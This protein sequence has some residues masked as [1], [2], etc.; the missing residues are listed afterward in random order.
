MKIFLS[1]QSRDK[2]LV[3]EFSQQ[4]PDFLTKWIDEDRLSWGDSLKTS[5]NSAIKVE[6][7]FLIVFIAE[8]TLESDWVRKEL[9]WALE[10][11]ATLGRAFI[12]PILIG[13]VDITSLPSELSDRLGLKLHD[14]S[15]L[16]VESLAKKATERLFKLVVESFD[17]YQMQMARLRRHSP[18]TRKQ[19]EILEFIANNRGVKS[20]KIEFKL[21]Y[22]RRS[23]ELMYRLTHLELLGLV[24]GIVITT[25]GIRSF[26][27]TPEYENFKNELRLISDI[28]NS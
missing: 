1:H 9:E 18:I 3:R 8:S 21:G 14:F 24:E 15:K 4:L 13:D 17:G 19:W 25:D 28:Y 2:A 12:L 27:V 5:L 16:S 20:K 6:S 26:S 7:D 11:E 22:D 10:R 23:A